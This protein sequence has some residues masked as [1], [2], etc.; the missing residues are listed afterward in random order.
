[1]RKY[2]YASTEREAQTRLTQVLADHQRGIPVASDRQTVAQFLE[3]WMDGV[4]SRLKPTTI[5]SYRS[6][7][8]NHINPAIGRIPLAKLNA[9]HVQG[10]VTV[11]IRNGSSTR[12]AQY[13]RAIV[14]AAL[15]DAER[16]G[17]VPRNVAALT[18]APAVRTKE[19]HA[20]TLKQVQRLLAAARRQGDEA[21]YAT[22]AGIGLRRGEA[23]GL[24]W[25]D[26]DFER[27]TLQ[28]RTQLQRTGADWQLTDLKSSGSQRT[29]PMPPGLLALLREHRRMQLEQRLKAGDRWHDH[30]L[31]FPSANGEPRRHG[32]ISRDLQRLLT[33]AGLPT[34]TFHELRHTAGSLMIEEGVHPK[35]ISELLG[36]S[37][38]KITMDIYGH[39]TTDSLRQATRRIDR[40]LDEREAGA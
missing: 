33:E 10:M 6:L 13:V 40:I 39:V 32:Q 12:T 11:T 28:V 8:A 1:V 16:W 23:F 21:L 25:R 24:R 15:G 35:T 31:V 5:K 4:E 9:Q 36:H 7:I 27:S 3:Q 38:I 17:M 34:L 37:S 22:A 14:R 30:D 2:V 29:I 18:D 26:I 20:L 19:R